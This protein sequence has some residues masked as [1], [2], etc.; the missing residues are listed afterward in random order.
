MKAQTPR[1]PL[2][3]IG[4]RVLS[5]VRTLRLARGLSYMDLSRSLTDL[6]RPI[7]PLGLSRLE[8]GERRVDVDDLVA[9]AHA[10]KVEAADLL[11]AEVSITMTGE[12]AR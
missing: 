1:N 9:L 3:T 2:G 12:D 8:S 6:G 7:P 4:H 11:F 5:N 10:L